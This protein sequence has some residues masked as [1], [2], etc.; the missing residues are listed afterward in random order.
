MTFLNREFSQG[1][2]L[3]EIKRQLN[4]YICHDILQLQLKMKTIFTLLNVASMYVLRTYATHLE[5]N[6][7]A[8]L[9]DHFKA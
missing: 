7:V 5:K 8:F 1:S 3:Y 6:S 4:L 9:I 2:Q